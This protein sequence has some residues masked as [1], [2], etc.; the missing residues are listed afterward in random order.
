[1]GDIFMAPP[2]P[3][4]LVWW[5]KTHQSVSRVPVLPIPE[6]PGHPA[7]VVAAYRLL[8]ASS[9]TTSVDQP[10][11][12]YLHRGHCTMVTVAILSRT[13]SALLHALS[14]NAGLFSLH[15]LCK[16]GAMA[17]YRLGLDQINI[18]WQ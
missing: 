8:L 18:K 9:P 16:R 4:I 1:M 14:F 3:Q 7:D 11:L 12:I 5:T 10:L 6:V 15:S 13:L 2:G 17:A